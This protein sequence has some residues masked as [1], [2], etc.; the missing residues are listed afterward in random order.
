MS[1]SNTSVSR[2]SH[3]H[4]EAMGLVVMARVTAMD[5]VGIAGVMEAVMV[6]SNPLQHHQP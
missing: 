3:R 2:N 4:K 1:R 5:T 6:A